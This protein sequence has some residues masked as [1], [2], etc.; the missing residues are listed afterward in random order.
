MLCEVCYNEPHTVDEEYC[1]S[2]S[3]IIKEPLNFKENRTYSINDDTSIIQSTY[4]RYS[5]WNWDHPGKKISGSLK[6]LKLTGKFIELDMDI[7]VA[8]RETYIY[9]G[10]R[11]FIKVQQLSK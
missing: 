8:A 1:H 2:I 11:K 4:D 5:P 7:E 10:R 9:K 6:V 3:F